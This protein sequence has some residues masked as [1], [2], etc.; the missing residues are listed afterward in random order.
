MVSS[1]K[2]SEGLL[3]FC[4]FFFPNAVSPVSTELNVRHSSQ[5]KLRVKRQGCQDGT[6]EHLGI[7]CC[8]CAAGQRVEE[9]CTKSAND[10]K[11]V[12]CENGTYNS[13]PNSKE[14]CEI[15]T[16][17]GP[18]NANLEQEEACTTIKDRTC[19]CKKGHYC[20]TAVG[21]CKIC[22]PCTRCSSSGV[23]EHCTATSDAVCNEESGGLSG[24]AVA[25][26]VI[27]VL[28]FLAALGIVFRKKILGFFK[29]DTSNSPVPENNPLLPVEMGPHI[30]ELAE[31]IG[32]KDMRQIALGC[33]MANSIENVKLSHPNDSEMWTQ[34]LLS[35]WVERKGRPASVE[36][37]TTLRKMRKNTKAD[38][39]KEKLYPIDS[40]TQCSS[41]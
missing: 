18:E 21:T 40:P 10:G 6:Y 14:S 30:V 38:K 1:R 25:G 12:Y 31:I 28:V 11:C 7:N 4:V 16:S 20:N 39:I 22:H 2:F 26:I 35:K 3:L 13:E 8:K 32:W 41:A 37:I 9:H 5:E 19:R 36:L 24:G 34:E 29:R 27:A 15:C 33:Q 17:C 23:K